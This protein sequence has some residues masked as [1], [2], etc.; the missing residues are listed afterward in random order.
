MFTTSII[1]AFTRVSVSLS[2]SSG[3]SALP[4]W[5]FRSEE[6]LA[7]GAA[8]QCANSSPLLAAGWLG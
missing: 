3:P 2:M 5:P 8:F 7:G 1:V 6:K 4:F